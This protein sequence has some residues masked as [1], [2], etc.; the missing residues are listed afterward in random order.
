MLFRSARVARCAA[1]GARQACGVA[2]QLALIVAGLLAEV[3]GIAL[4]VWEVSKRRNYVREY[5]ERPRV[6]TGLGS[7]TW[8][9]RGRAEGRAPG[10]PPT[11]EQRLD[12][13]EAGLGAVR[14]EV[15][16]AERRAVEVAKAHVSEVSL[17]VQARAKRDVD[18]V[19]DLLL[20]VTEPT[21]PV[22]TSLGLLVLGVALQSLASALGV[23]G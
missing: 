13:L 18:E 3:V 11:V 20:R 10:E 14:D 6:A 8:G 12:A 9:F 5:R 23:N 4:A 21:W 15:E 7:G 16:H 1:T 19:R 17:D 22:W 2:A